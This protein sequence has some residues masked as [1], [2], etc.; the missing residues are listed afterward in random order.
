MK[1]RTLASVLREYVPKGQGIDFLSIDVEG[2]D[3]EVL[4]SMDWEE[5][6]PE[7][8]LVEQELSALDELSSSKITSF[9]K[10]VGY[11]VQ[12]WIPP[13]LVFVHKAHATSTVSPTALESNPRLN[14]R[15]IA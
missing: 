7:L 5:F 13:T 6:R 14:H 15:S 4:Q 3:L 9:M 11:D 1:T 12:A 2:H 8:V 10:S